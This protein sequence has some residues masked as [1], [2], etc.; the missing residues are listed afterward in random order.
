[1]IRVPHFMVDRKQKEQ[2]GCGAGLQPSK[3]WSQQLL[4]ATG[5]YLLPYITSLKQPHQLSMGMPIKCPYERHQWPR[6]QIPNI[7]RRALAIA[8][9]CNLS[10]PMWKRE[11]EA[12][13]CVDAHEPSRLCGV[14]SD[15]EQADSVSH[16]QDGKERHPRLSSDCTKMLWLPCAHML[17]CAHRL[18]CHV[19]TE[20]YCLLYMTGRLPPCTL[21]NVVA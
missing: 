12:G 5:T 20:I 11:A 17:R 14:H 19:S 15:K 4:P 13:D 8:H 6:V 10:A 18:T 1:M 16:K 2:A 7:H 9:I 3:I 21:N